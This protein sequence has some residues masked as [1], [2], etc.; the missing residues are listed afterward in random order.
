MNKVK[1]SFVVDL[2]MTMIMDY[3]SQN[4]DGQENDRQ[5][6][7][8]NCG[9]S[10]TYTQKIVRNIVI[11]YDELTEDG[12]SI[13]SLTCVKCKKEY[14]KDNKLY[15]LPVDV[16][17]L[18]NVEYESKEDEKTITINKKK[19]FVK[20]STSKD[21][22]THK[23]V[24]DSLMICKKTNKI[25]SNINKPFYSNFF[26]KNFDKD[27][28]VNYNLD[29]TN[30]SILEEF[31]HYKSSINYY[32]IGNCN[33]ML[34]F[35]K[36]LTKDFK[37][38]NKEIQFVNYTFSESGKIEEVSEGEYVSYFQNVP[39][40]FGDGKIIR[41]KVVTGDYL[42]NLLSCYKLLFSVL[43]FEPSSTIILTKDYNFFKKW[44]ESDFV[45]EPEI[46]ISQ[47]A[48]NPN[49][50]M[51]T[52]LKFNKK[53][54][55][56]ASFKGAKE[57]VYNF[58]M[59]STIYNSLRNVE[60]LSVLGK[61]YSFGILK[62]NEIEELIQKYENSKIYNLLMNIVN[63]KNNDILVSYKNIEHILKNDFYIKNKSGN[64]ASSYSGDFLTIYIDTIRVIDLLN[65][66]EK[67]IFKCKNYSSLKEMHDD[68][69]ARFN[70]MKDLKKAEL[71]ISAVEE[72]LEL[73]CKI[74]DVEI[75][76]VPTSEKLNLEGLKMKHCIYTY[77]NRIC[78]KRYLAIN[79]TH[80][81]TGERATAGFTRSGKVLKFEQLKG[82]YNS[83]ATE[84][85]IFCAQKFCNENNI[86]ITSHFDLSVDKNR[87]RLMENQ[88]T[89]SDLEDLRNLKK[90]NGE[91]LSVEVKDKFL[92]ISKKKNKTD[93]DKSF[94]KNIKNL[95]VF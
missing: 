13:S 65:L 59:S 31:F 1:P 14:N 44:I 3:T 48:T 95:F 2:S 58:K 92:K 56:R 72:F 22:I 12:E 76:V 38:F 67:T 70:A 91:E 6:L 19:N 37:T 4:Q 47:N 20:Y 62:K 60:D 68:Y 15:L 57:D 34:N 35:L 24:V 28:K 25:S 27:V 73:N 87:Q 51:E 85:M 53:G 21:S 79:L 16:D 11:N 32:G 89:E 42:V 36:K 94:L 54:Q 52:S 5:K 8:C 9:S 29:L 18:Y 71:Y 55:I 84:E 39:S 40:G 78:E 66:K 93:T 45:C 83:R 64:N 80:S 50:I 69:S 7:F 82:F 81:I 88:M 17:E 75:E 63:K 46:Y 61:V 41:K 49:K 10:Q 77:L 23:Q 30:V 26:E 86:K 74:G 90:E 43:S 33:M